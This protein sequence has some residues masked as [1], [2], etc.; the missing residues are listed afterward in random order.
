MLF[1]LYDYDLPITNNETRHINAVIRL[2]YWVEWVQDY[3]LVLML[4]SQRST[5]GL[6]ISALDRCANVL[7]HVCLY[8]QDTYNTTSIS[9]N[10]QP[11]TYPT[12]PIF[13][14]NQS[15]RK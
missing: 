3:V 1:H 4:Y 7:K 9:R 8:S 13:K 5:I 14:S 11:S 15:N 12:N 2:T 6:V 10:L